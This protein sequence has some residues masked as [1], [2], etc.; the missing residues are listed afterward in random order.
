MMHDATPG[1]NLVKLLFFCFC[2]AGLFLLPA[3]A[4]AYEVLPEPARNAPADELS[5]G[6]AFGL[7]TS[8]YKSYDTQF[9][10]FPLIGYE[11]RYAYIRGFTAG[12]KVINHE[13]L[14]FSVFAGYDPAS[15]DAADTSDRRLRRLKDRY[16]G[17]IAGIAARV[18]TPCGVFQASGAAN[19]SG[20]SGGITAAFGYL[21]PLEYG[22]L[23]VIPSV[24]V[25][26]DDRRYNGYYYGISGNEARGSG[27][28][29]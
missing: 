17:V 9:S 5:F 27:L 18:V 16:S 28:D 26:W 2:C 14:E 21:L 13:K 4:A 23:E 6:V 22:P 1:V 24:G 12:V 19:V 8:P 15:F 25:R 20:Q 3:A 29:E 11:G 7:G 10:A